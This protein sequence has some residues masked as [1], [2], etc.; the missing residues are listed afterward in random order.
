MSRLLAVAAALLLSACAT[1]ADKK[2]VQS[3]EAQKWGAGVKTYSADSVADEIRRLPPQ[4]HPNNTMAIP[5]G[6]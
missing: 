4:N 1:D 3:V 2:N 5:R 6:R